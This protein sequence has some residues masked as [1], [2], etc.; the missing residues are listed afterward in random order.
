MRAKQ[1]NA[2]TQIR[3]SKMQT[4]AP[5]PNKKRELKQQRQQHQARRRLENN[6]II[7]LQISQEF[8]YGRNIHKGGICTPYFTCTRTRRMRSFHL[9]FGQEPEE[10]PR[11]GKRILTH[12]YM[13]SAFV[14]VAVVV[15]LKET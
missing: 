12:A 3:W 4:E 13:H 5:R 2:Q 11:N 1:R 10:R 14:L 7:N 9:L 8:R 15:S 6:F